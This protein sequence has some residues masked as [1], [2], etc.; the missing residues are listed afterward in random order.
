MVE[1]MAFQAV[2]M[3]VVTLL[4]LLSG[5][6]YARVGGSDGGGDPLPDQGVRGEFKLTAEKPFDE[7]K[8]VL[9]CP[10]DRHPL[11]L[12]VKAVT[13]PRRQAFMLTLLA[14]PSAGKHGKEITIG[15]F[16]LFPSDQPARFFIDS[17]PLKAVGC[18]DTGSHPFRFRLQIEAIDTALV[19]PL[20]IQAVIAPLSSDQP[21][22]P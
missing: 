20:A 9:P 19:G 13:N 8:V 2:R 3:V 21:P 11:V 15:S 10:S 14:K 17:R 12:W 5:S 1:H 6:G 22:S 4:V 16:S 18:A 7:K